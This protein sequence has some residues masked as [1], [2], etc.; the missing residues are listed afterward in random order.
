MLFFNG[1]FPNL[2]FPVSEM[3]VSDSKIGL[4]LKVLNIKRQANSGNDFSF[5]EVFL[6]DTST[7][8]HD[9]GKFA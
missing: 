3:A 1:R 9:A 6:F 4:H 8:N 5:C 2:S 7:E